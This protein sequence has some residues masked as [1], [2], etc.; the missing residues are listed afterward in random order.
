[1]RYHIL[2]DNFHR[3][4]TKRWWFE[5]LFF[6]A[7]KKLID[8]FPNEIKTKIRYLIKYYHDYDFYLMKI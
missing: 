3:K 2:V 8:G 5:F 6:K 1:M 4:S 7:R